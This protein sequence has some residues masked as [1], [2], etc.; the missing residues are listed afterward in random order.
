MFLVVFF[1]IDAIVRF[2]LDI[3][4]KITS[5]SSIILKT[6]CP[7]RSLPSKLTK[8]LDVVFSL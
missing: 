6:S 3:S 5:S 7:I 8:T 4:K 2:V 1:I